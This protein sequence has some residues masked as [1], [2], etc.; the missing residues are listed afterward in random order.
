MR[1]S[2]SWIASAVR[3][4]TAVARQ[5]AST[6]IARVR[7]TL[8]T[9]QDRGRAD[10]G[11]TERHHRHVSRHG[12]APRDSMSDAPVRRAQAGQGVAHALLERCVGYALARR[13]R[14][15]SLVLTKPE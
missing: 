1:S 11:P 5:A 3:G 4:M 10:G 12:A 8:R 6:A 9:A 2:G 15:L 13:R 7:P 14:T